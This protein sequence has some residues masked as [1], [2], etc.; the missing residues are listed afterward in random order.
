MCNGHVAGLGAVGLRVMRTL[1]LPLRNAKPV[2]DQR[3]KLSNPKS[4][5]PLVLRPVGSA[6]RQPLAG[7]IVANLRAQAAEAAQNAFAA[8]TPIGGAPDVRLL[9]ARIPDSSQGN[10]GGEVDLAA[11]LRDQLEAEPELM[12]AL[13]EAAARLPEEHY[14]TPPAETPPSTGNNGVPAACAAASAKSCPPQPPAMETKQDSVAALTR[15]NDDRGSD[16]GEEDAED[17]KSKVGTDL[18]SD[19]SDGICDNDSDAGSDKE[20]PAPQSDKAEHRRRPRSPSPTG[21][22]AVPQVYRYEFGATDDVDVCFVNLR[23]R[24]E[25]ELGR[26]YT[27]Q[28]CLSVAR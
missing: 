25:V 24:I 22:S 12:Q 2:F 26:G 16:K 21:H 17:D 1:P 15:P 27:V 6:I 10:A 8:S 19:A 9:E 4:R 3:A 23:R 5:E 11:A 14:E 13:V 18:A 28:M 7:A 20:Q